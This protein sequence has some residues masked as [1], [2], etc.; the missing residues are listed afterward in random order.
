MQINT[1]YGREI[2]Q[3]LNVAIGGTLVV[4]VVVVFHG[5]PWQATDVLQPSWL[6][7]TARFGRSNFGH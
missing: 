5:P 4:V 6:S 3:F 1:L 2:K 7:G